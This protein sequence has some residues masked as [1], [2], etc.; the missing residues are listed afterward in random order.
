M[1]S[2][3]LPSDHAGIEPWPEF[4]EEGVEVL[5]GHP[6]QSGRIDWGNEEGPM[7]VG[8]WEC[9]PGKVRL[10]KPYSEFCTVTR[11]RVTITDGEG[12]QTTFGPGDGFF[13]AQGELSTWDIHEAFQVTFFFHISES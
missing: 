2:Y 10:V 11:G 9:T 8:V 7:A 4:E 3:K 5:E 13:I 12:I 6:K 1:H